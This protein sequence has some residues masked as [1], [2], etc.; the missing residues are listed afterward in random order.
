MEP[1]VT[2][3]CRFVER[4]GKRAAIGS[5]ADVGRLVDGSAGTQISSGAKVLTWHD[6]VGASLQAAMTAGGRPSSSSGRV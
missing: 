5:I 6:E 3:A 1:K 2:A 4:T